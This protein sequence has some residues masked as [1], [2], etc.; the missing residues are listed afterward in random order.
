MILSTQTIR[1]RCEVLTLYAEL[2][3]RKQQHQNLPTL[4]RSL[5]PVRSLRRN[6]RK[7]TVFRKHELDIG[8]NVMR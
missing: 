3:Y 1:E 4:K 6:T 5:D 7:R 8:G 2:R